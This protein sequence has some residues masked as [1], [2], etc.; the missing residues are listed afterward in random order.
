MHIL[1]TSEF[2]WGL[3]SEHLSAVPFKLAQNCK[4]LTITFSTFAVHTQPN[5]INLKASTQFILPNIQSD[6]CAWYQKSPSDVFIVAT[7][8]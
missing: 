6:T 3:Q 1:S 8:N 5:E 2:E 4:N 7:A